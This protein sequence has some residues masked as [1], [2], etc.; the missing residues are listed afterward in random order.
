[1]RRRKSRYKKRYNARPRRRYKKRNSG[2]KKAHKDMLK[3]AGVA[4]AILVFSQDTYAWIL[5]KLGR[6]S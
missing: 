3:G 6:V 2:M 4:T 5:Q 1:M